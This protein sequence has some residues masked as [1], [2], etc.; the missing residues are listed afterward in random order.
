MAPLAVLFGA[1]LAAVGLVGYLAPGTFGEFDKVSP[2]S[3]IPAAVGGVLIL[4]GLVTLA[5]PA[6]RKHAMHLAALAGVVGLLGG[7]MP[8]SRS[9]FNFA[10]ASA[11]SGALMSGLSLLFVILCVKSFIDARRA[12]LTSAS[13]E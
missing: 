7:F 2:T 11:V 8:L 4:C 6:A 12:R 5:K 3:L 9:N 13:P 10:K 1:L